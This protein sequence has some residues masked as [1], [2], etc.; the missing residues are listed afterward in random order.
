MTR[1]TK[2]GFDYHGGYLTYQRKFVARFKYSRSPIKM[3][4]F[5][6]FLIKHMDVEQYFGHLEAGNSP[7]PIIEAYGFTWSAAGKVY[8]EKRPELN[9]AA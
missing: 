3:A 9:K 2:D 4:A 6:N 5:R 1:F 8:P 7:L